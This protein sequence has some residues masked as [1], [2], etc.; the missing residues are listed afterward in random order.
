M[1]TIKESLLVC[2]SP[3]NLQIEVTSMCNLKCKMCPL[4]T[5]N[6][7]SSANPGHMTNVLW[8][9]ILPLAK[10]YGKVLLCGYGESLLNPNFLSLLQELNQAKIYMSMSTNGTLLTTSIA[11][12]LTAFEYLIHINISIDS[13]ESDSYHHIRGGNVEK[14]LN[15]LKNLLAVIKDPNR[16]TVS[17]ILMA[18]NIKDLVRFPNFLAELGVRKFV[19]QGLVDYNASCSEAQLLHNREL[20][21]YLDEIHQQCKETGIEIT[22]TMAERL[23]LER[24]NPAKAVHR[25]HSTSMEPGETKQCNVPWEIPFIDREGRVFPCCSAS[26]DGA[27]VMGD[28]KHESWDEIWNGL[29]FREFR[30]CLLTGTNI[31]T[32]CQSCNGAPRGKHPFLL[33]ALEIMFEQ[34]RLSGKKSMKL[35][36]KNIGQYTWAQNDP[37]RIGTSGPRDRSSQ[38]W[39]PTWISVNRV[40]HFKEKQVPPGGL[41]TFEFEVN[42]TAKVES[43]SFELVYDGKTWMHNT[44]FKVTT[45]RKMSNNPMFYATKFFGSFRSNLYEYVQTR[46]LR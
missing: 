37:I 36:V 15:G 22:M 2:E 29:R 21:A 3:R 4:T 26:R 14:A 25:F 43:E 30:K 10:R 18:H 35:V 41:A 19:L 20:F 31:P 17:S 8:H 42:T 44:Q 39:H 6:T 1:N 40:A 45:P 7:L 24:Y 9:N 33:Y 16:V 34:S 13:P 11:S 38:L 12:E 23:E 28:L 27:A 5:G 46:N 32:I